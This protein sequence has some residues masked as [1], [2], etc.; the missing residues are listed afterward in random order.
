[1][2]LL[3]QLLD[4]YKKKHPNDWDAWFNKMAKDLIETG[5]VTKSDYIKFC[6]ENDVSIR[7]S[8]KSKKSD[9]SSTQIRPSSYN[10]DPCSRP[11]QRSGC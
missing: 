7:P 6:A 8:I 4:I 3:Q 10:S 9:S 1:M 11:I 2:E 5:D